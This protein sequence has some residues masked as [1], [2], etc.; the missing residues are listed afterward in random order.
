MKSRAA[1]SESSKLVASGR[2]KLQHRLR[3][4]RPHAGRGDRFGDRVL[5]VIHVGEAGDAR[6]DH[7]GAGQARAEPDEVRTHE[8]ALDGHHVSH[9]PDVQPQVVGQ[10]AYERHRRVRVCV[11]EPRHHDAAT[12]V[13]RL[14]CG[15]AV[16]ARPDGYDRGARDGEPAGGVHG[17]A[18]V[19]REHER[20]GQT[21]V[22]GRHRTIPSAVYDRGADGQSA[23]RDQRLRASRRRR[24]RRRRWRRSEV[25][26]KDVGLILDDLVV[27]RHL[28]Q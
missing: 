9:Q 20:I 25:L 12:A 21:N 19:H 28:E 26:Q 11:D 16:S 27:G 15:V 17:E 13:P 7:F 23:P 24:R 4:E 3:A 6:P 2:G 14:G 10:P 1:A 8:L 22:A 5:E 18:L